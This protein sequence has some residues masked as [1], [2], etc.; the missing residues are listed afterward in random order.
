MQLIE[1]SISYKLETTKLTEPVLDQKLEQ[2]QT[3]SS[4]HRSDTESK[5]K[6]TL[7]WFM[8]ECS[9]LRSE[10]IIE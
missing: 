5:G 2:S 8:D 1:R 3:P 9:K 10:W 4:H 7:R 6:L